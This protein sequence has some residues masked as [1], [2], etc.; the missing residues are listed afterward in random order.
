MAEEAPI[1]AA[2]TAWSAT[3]LKSKRVGELRELAAAV[4]V[5]PGKKTKADLIQALLAAASASA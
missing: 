1:G 2:Q 3:A 4:G 5:V